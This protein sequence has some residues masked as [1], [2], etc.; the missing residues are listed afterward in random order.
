M[1]FICCVSNKREREREREGEREREL[2]KFEMRHNFMH[3][4]QPQ[5]C[6]FELPLYTTAVLIEKLAIDMD[7]F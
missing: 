6:Y 5:F 2:S 7:S 1:Q 4:E 3:G